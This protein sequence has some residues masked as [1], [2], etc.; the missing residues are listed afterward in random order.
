MEGAG[1]VPVGA[2]GPRQGK[3]AAVKI[4]PG[5]AP[6]HC[7]FL[8]FTALPG[9]KRQEPAGSGLP[10]TLSP[11]PEKDQQDLS[12]SF[13]AW[14]GSWG[15][16]FWWAP[17]PE[18]PP[19]PWGGCTRRSKR[20]WR[21][22]GFPAP[23]PTRPVQGTEGLA[24]KNSCCRSRNPRRV[25]VRKRR[26]GE[27]AEVSLSCRRRGLML[28]RARAGLC[29][30]VTGW[31]PAGGAGLPGVNGWLFLFLILYM[32]LLPALGSVR[33]GS[34]RS[35]SCVRLEHPCIPAL[36]PSPASQRGLR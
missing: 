7:G 24:G 22:H 27:L 23:F 11:P 6:A 30:G 3:R 26:R 36:H 25:P 12:S 2:L 8:R 4:T 34:R 19:A 32:R 18:R 21:G 15:G 20:C 14:A 9:G 16:G 31:A 29:R 35:R 17:A 1:I 28:G 13:P 33:S 10:L 5:P